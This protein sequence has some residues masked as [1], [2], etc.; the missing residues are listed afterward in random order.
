MK[1]KLFIFIFFILSA[2]QA[3]D[4]PNLIWTDLQRNNFIEKLYNPDKFFPVND[5]R[6]LNEIPMYLVQADMFNK[7]MNANVDFTGKWI[8]PTTGFKEAYVIGGEGTIGFSAAALISNAT[9]N[10]AMA[11]NVVRALADYAEDANYSFAI[12]GRIRSEI[13]VASPNA[14]NLVFTTASKMSQYIIAMGLVGEILKGDP[15]Y[16]LKK[17]VINQWFADSKVFFKECL[18]SK[19]SYWIFGGW[20]SFENLTFR[21]TANT[22]YLYYDVNANPYI[23]VPDAVAGA[24][25]NRD[26]DLASFLSKYGTYYND[27]DARDY[28][29]DYFKLMMKCGIIG[30]NSENIDFNRS[31]DGSANNQNKGFGYAWNIANNM[32]LMAHVN[33]VAV[34]KGVLPQSDKGKYYNHKEYEGA[35]DI[36]QSY[37]FFPTGSTVPKTIKSTILSIAK[38]YKPASF[39]GYYGDRYNEDAVLMNP[40]AHTYTTPAFVADMYYQD[41]ELEAIAK[42]N[43][44]DGYLPYEKYGATDIGRPHVFKISWDLGAAVGATTAFSSN[45]R[46]FKSPLNNIK[47]PDLPN[48]TSLATDAQGNIIEG[49]TGGNG[50]GGGSGG[51]G[52]GETAAETLLRDNQALPPLRTNRTADINL[53]KISTTYVGGA[54]IGRKVINY[55]TVALNYTIVDDFDIDDVLLFMTSGF[56]ANIIPDTGDSFLLNGVATTGGATISGNYNRHAAVKVDTNLWDIVSDGVVA[57]TVPSSNLYVESSAANAENESNSIGSFVIQ[58]GATSGI[59]VS[60]SAPTVTGG[61]SSSINLSYTNSASIPFERLVYNYSGYT[62]GQP[63]TVSFYW[64]RISGTSTGAFRIEGR[65]GGTNEIISSSTTDT[66]WSSTPF[67]YTF[68]PTSSSGQI[69]WYGNWNDSTAQAIEFEITNL[70]ITQ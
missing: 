23:S 37:P 27:S 29:F 48:A 32:A 56:D 34:E 47:L 11:R 61:S 3:Q 44:A 58:T 6:F 41:G 16:E 64:R 17:P 30:D 7:E 2:I 57:F 10:N 33:E 13:D 12:G 52:A 46:V 14:S 53:A 19:V 20:R 31:N 45:E 65:E 8:M 59:T 43:P 42:L 49:T 28:A 54:D 21:G 39:G 55:N 68:T 9:G 5:D 18:E 62:V 15:Y 60:N 4:V 35:E 25:N 69:R 26:M 24:V 1:T 70:E 38:Y 51:N 63:V 22:N 67:T 40:I 36:F 66:G 50:A